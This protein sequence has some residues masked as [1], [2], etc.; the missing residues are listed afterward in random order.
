MWGRKTQVTDREGETMQE[1][2]KVNFSTNG[3]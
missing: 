1:E 3:H 2:L